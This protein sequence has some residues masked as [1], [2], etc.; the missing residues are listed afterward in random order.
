M[1]MIATNAFEFELELENKYQTMNK[2]E[3]VSMGFR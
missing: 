1:V 2:S 3:N